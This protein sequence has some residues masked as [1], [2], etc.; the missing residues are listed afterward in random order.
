MKPA[1]VSL[2]GLKLR[3]LEFISAAGSNWQDIIIGE[4]QE[5]IHQCIR[6]YL[7]SFEDSGEIRCVRHIAEPS[8]SSRYF[9][10]G[11]ELHAF[12][13]GVSEQGISLSKEVPWDENSR[14]SKPARDQVNSQQKIVE[15]G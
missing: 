15:I 9:L 2:R 12:S 10:H 14:A 8:T 6:Q 5:A 3:R 4:D 1:V 7:M 13:R 11:R